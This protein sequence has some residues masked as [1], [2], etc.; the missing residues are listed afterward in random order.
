MIIS[1]VVVQKKLFFPAAEYGSEFV[2][3]VAA[4]KAVCARCPVREQCLAWALDV[5]PH[6]VAGGLAEH[7]RRSVRTTGGTRIRITC[8]T[9][10]APISAVRAGEGHGGNR[11][12]PLISQ[13]HNPQAGTRAAEGPERR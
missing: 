9:S 7:E 12:L 2:A 3:Q 6:G 5:L 4:A 8:T 13:Q 11:A 1:A 10:T